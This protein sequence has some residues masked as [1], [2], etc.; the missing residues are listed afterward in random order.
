MGAAPA[1]RA[2]DTRASRLPAVAVGVAK[3]THLTDF[4]SAYPASRTSILAYLRLDS[5]EVNPVIRNLR[6]QSAIADRKV[7]LETNGLSLSDFTR[8]LSRT[9][10]QVD[11]TV[12]TLAHAIAHYRDKNK[13]FFIRPFCEMNDATEGNPW[14]FGCKGHKNTPEDFV[15]AW[16]LLRDVFDQEGA[17]NAIFVFSP[18]AAYRVHRE[19]DVLK[20]LNLMP[21]GYIDCFGLNVYSRP[22]AVY[23]GKSPEPISFAALTDPWLKL[24]ARSRQRGIPLAVAEMA[25]SNQA[26][27]ARRALWVHDA[28]RFARMRGCVLITYFNYPHR[29]WQIDDETLAGRALREEM[30]APLVTR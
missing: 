12:R 26:T 10:S 3:I 14:E 28:F 21:R 11:Y 20:T 16:K 9:A 17:T 25:V 24:L 8:E 6:M 7:A 1:A 23:G 5:E 30:G 29:Y 2:V 4:L 19:E 22:L 27:D 15:A 13:W 18:L